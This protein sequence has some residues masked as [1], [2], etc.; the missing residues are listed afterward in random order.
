MNVWIVN[1]S[2]SPMENLQRA[3]YG[4][5]EPSSWCYLIDLAEWH[6]KEGEMMYGQV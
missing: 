4:K 3:L 5:E 1:E 6:A 2:T